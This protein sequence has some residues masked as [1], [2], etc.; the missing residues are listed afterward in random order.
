ML[1]PEAKEGLTGLKNLN[2]KE[3]GAIFQYTTALYKPLV[4]A[5]NSFSTKEFKQ[6]DLLNKEWGSPLA[7]LKYT[8]PMLQAIS[9]GLT[10]LPLYT[11]KVYRL[12]STST[13]LLTMSLK[14]RQRY[15]ARYKVGSIQTQNYPMSTAKSLDS[16]F[17][18][19]NYNN[20]AFSVVFEIENIKTGHDIQ[21]VSDKV[22]EEEVLF[23]PGSR[24]QVISVSPHNPDDPG[25]KH[26]WV[27]LQEV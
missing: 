22:N 11:G 13:P 17:A 27:K 9:S 2:D 10:K 1:P 4:N 26:I 6:G 25:D 24:L 23:A 7:T 3:L 20:P 18:K 21:F 5:S 8:G 14:E 15:A 19:T 12:D 16:Q